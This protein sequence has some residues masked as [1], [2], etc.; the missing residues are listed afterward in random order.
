[1]ALSSSKKFATADSGSA[2]SGSTTHRHA[3][4]SRTGDDAVCTG[5]SGTKKSIPLG[6]GAGTFDSE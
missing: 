6:P 5:G 4:P 1:M 2:G 3:L